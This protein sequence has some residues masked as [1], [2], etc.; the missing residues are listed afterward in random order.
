MKNDHNESDVVE[1]INDTTWKITPVE[2]GDDLIICLPEELCNH[3]GV[4]I[5]DVLNWII[6]DDG[7]ILLEKKKY[8][9]T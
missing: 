4:E 3:M 5:D 9:E 7:T 8:D 1:K 6:T 2:D